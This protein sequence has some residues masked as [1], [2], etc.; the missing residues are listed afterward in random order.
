MQARVA[1]DLAALVLPGV[2]DNQR[3]VPEVQRAQNAQN[4]RRRDRAVQVPVVCLPPHQVPADS[5]AMQE[6]GST[7]EKTMNDK[8]PVTG[9]EVAVRW[10]IVKNNGAW[11]ARCPKHKLV[12]QGNSWEDLVEMAREVTR[13]FLGRD[14]PIEWSKAS[15]TSLLILR[16]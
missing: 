3:H 10:E 6:R 14:A 5:A 1:L 16:F 15:A 11:V 7:A 9:L 13:D 12:A 8:G 4:D 2:A